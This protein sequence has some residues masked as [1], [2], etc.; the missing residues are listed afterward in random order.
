MI[1][2]KFKIIPVVSAQDLAKVVLIRREVFVEEQ[3]VPL[4]E[5]FDHFDTLE[6]VQADDV[7]HLLALDESKIIGTG[8]LIL[9]QD[10]SENSHLAQIGR[11]AVVKELRRKNIGSALMTKFHELAFDLGFSGIILSAHFEASII[12]FNPQS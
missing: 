1:S 4:K 10:P 11:I 7:V 9:R 8:R 5:E 6:A 12:A 3:K 2:K